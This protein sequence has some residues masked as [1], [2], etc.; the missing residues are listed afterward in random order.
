M[1]KTTGTLRYSLNNRDKW[2]LV[3]DCDQQII[4]YYKHL[5]AEERHLNLNIPRHGS[6]VTVIEGEEPLKNIE[7]WGEHNGE[8][9]DLKATKIYSINAFE[10]N[11]EKIYCINIECE[12]LEEL[13]EYFGL[14]PEY[15]FH[16]T[17]G[18]Y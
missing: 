13:R 1:F 15:P 16:I 3:V 2:W 14:E 8:V 5:C 9:I 12:R 4:R 6:H 11:R 7:K 17:I 10:Q 18:L